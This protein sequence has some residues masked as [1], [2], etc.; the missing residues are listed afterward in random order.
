MTGQG[1][2]RRGQGRRGDW[3]E[4]NRQLLLLLQPAPPGRGDSAQLQ[5]PRHPG[6]LAH[7]ALAGADHLATHILHSAGLESFGQKN[8]MHNM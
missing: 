2:N 4:E 6:V 5:R 7:G 8:K 1:Q 3:Q